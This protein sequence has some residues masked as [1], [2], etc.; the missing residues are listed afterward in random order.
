VAVLCGLTVPVC[1][2]RMS[3]STAP[4]I[5][6]APVPMVMVPSKARPA[7]FELVVWCAITVVILTVMHRA[8]RCDRR[9]NRDRCDHRYCVR[10]FLYESPTGTVDF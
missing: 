5:V 10:D 1:L 4:P 2:H 7:T 9:N 8:S 3:E 6:G